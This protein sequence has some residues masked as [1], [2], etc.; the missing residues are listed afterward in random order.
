MAK[1]WNI[2]ELLRE[3]IA[4]AGGPVSCHAHFDKAY[5]ITPEKLDMT[6]EHMEVKWDLWKKVK[7][8]YTHENLVE[9]ISLSAENM[10]RQ[11]CTIT[12]TNVD[13]DAT[14]GMKCVEAA[15]EVK[16]KYADKIEIQIASQVLEGALNPES[17]KMIEKAEPFVD[18]LGGLPSRDRPHQSEHLDYLFDLAKRKKKTVDVHID[19]NNFPEERDTELLAKKVIEHGLQGRVNAVHALSLAAQ[20]D[21]YVRD[22]AQLLKEA[23]M[24]VLICPRAA[25]DMMQMREKT[26][27]LHNS[28]APM[29]QLL[30]AGV[31]VALGVD[32]VYD[33]FCPFID[34]DIFTELLFLSEACR[35]YDVEKLVD[36]ATKN[37]RKVLANI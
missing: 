27:P 34:G 9:R 32:N 20:P 3:K 18:A 35:F 16:E 22:I 4:A 1:P 37:G 25:I 13:V 17:Q 6:M 29:P 8:E 30:E 19:Q 7:E 21:E 28:I 5:V 15:L 14:V 24:S 23:E 26:A 12:R 10:I 33:F 11:G 2:L 36:I 31:N